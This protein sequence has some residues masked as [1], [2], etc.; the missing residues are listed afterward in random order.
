MIETN[1]LIWING[2]IVEE[3]KFLI[4]PM[5][6]T[7]HY[8]TG[9]FD[10]IMAY[11]DKKTKS[12]NI[13]LGTEHFN[14]L[15]NSSKYFNYN[16]PFNEDVLIN[17]TLRLLKESRVTCNCYIRP[18]IFRSNADLNLSINKKTSKECLA[19]SI[20]RMPDNLIMNYKCLITEVE[21]LSSKSIPIHLK[22]CASYTNS[23]LARKY[24]KDKDFDDGFMIDPNGN[25]TEI[26][27]ANVFFIDKNQKICTPKLSGYVFPGL[28]RTKVCSILKES[29]IDYEENEIHKSNMN[30][31]TGAFLSATFKEISPIIN[32]NNIELD[33]LSNE[34]YNEILDEFKKSIYGSGQ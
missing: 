20:S 14:R 25:I 9:I 12:F 31:Y 28:T 19:I 11:F 21:R 29:G 24:A 5:S 8:A 3:A 18:I 16:I 4:S 13:Y 30:Q 32:I 22:S 6:N 26:S 15:L 34:V 1:K 23:Y 2:E 17:A 27:T 7:L 10:G 33:T